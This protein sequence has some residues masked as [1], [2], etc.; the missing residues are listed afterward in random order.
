MSPS[1]G[2]RCVASGTPRRGVAGGAESQ[3]ATASA[4]TTV[5]RASEAERMERH[6]SR[7]RRRTRTGGASAAEALERL[8]V[9]RLELERGL[10]G[11]ARAGLAARGAADVAE[12]DA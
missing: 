5:E 6:R 7:A 8:A 3:P 4:R 2:V 11:L 12:E 10:P 1:V 9:L